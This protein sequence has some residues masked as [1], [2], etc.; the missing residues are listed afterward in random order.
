M[1]ALQANN[2]LDEVSDNPEITPEEMAQAKPFSEVFPELAE[3][4]RRTRGQQ[5]APTKQL[6]SIRL[7]R[8]VLDA[9]RA[10][11]DGWQGRMN[12]ALRAHAAKLARSR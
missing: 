10:T 11:G 1:S 4:I 6:I 3:S 7:D 9:F 2:E 5:K 12:E 8:D